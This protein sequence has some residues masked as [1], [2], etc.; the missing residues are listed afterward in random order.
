MFTSINKTLFEHVITHERTNFRHHVETSFSTNSTPETIDQ[1]SVLF[2]VPAN[3]QSMNIL[4]DGIHCHCNY[5]ASDGSPKGYYYCTSYFMESVTSKFINIAANASFKECINTIYRYQHAAQKHFYGALL[6][7]VDNP[8]I[9]INPYHILTTLSILENTEYLEEMRF[10]ILIYIHTNRERAD[11]DYQTYRSN[12]KLVEENIN[13]LMQ[14]YTSKLPTIRTLK[15]ITPINTEF[16]LQHQLKVDYTELIYKDEDPTYAYYLVA[17]QIVTKGIICPY[18]GTSLVSWTR[19]S[20]IECAG[21]SLSPMN[22]CNISHNAEYYYTESHL[23]TEM[24]SVCT[25]DESNTSYIGLRTL[26]HSN[27]SSAYRPDNLKIGFLGYVDAMIAKA[28]EL[29]LLAGILQ[30][31]EDAPTPSLEQIYTEDQLNSTTLAE[32]VAASPADTPLT[33][34]R[35]N[36]K[37]MLAALEERARSQATTVCDTANPSD[38]CT[39]SISA[40]SSESSDVC[41][42]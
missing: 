21:R 16:D 18:Y 19:G 26:A 33:T 34:T 1:G 10:N 11:N 15:D 36:F 20:D 35:R 3:K 4:T 32:F 6:R 29:Y 23:N 14:A 25:G 39:T 8:D 7:S 28:T 30:P 31:L 27:L 13:A 41:Q 38:E 42:A 37:T 40:D 9:I 22:S 12:P 17:H 5:P 24:Q 2:K